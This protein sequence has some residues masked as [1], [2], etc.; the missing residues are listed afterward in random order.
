M[1]NDVAADELLLQMSSGRAPFVL[2]VRSRAEFDAGHVPGAASMPF[3][4]VPFRAATLPVKPDD[5]IVVYCGHGPRAQLATA[6]L[7][8][9]GF[10][11]IAC[12][13]G[14]WAE[15]RASGH[16]EQRAVLREVQR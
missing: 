14:H 9:R 6:A 11:R 16:P 10:T 4:M 15:W 7:R 2:D 1:S 13:A 5:P 12:L 8:A 3:W